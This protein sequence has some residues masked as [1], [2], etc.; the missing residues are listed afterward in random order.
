[1]EASA[2]G[3]QRALRSLGRR[4]LRERVPDAVR[5]EVLRYVE[6][7]RH[8]GRPWSEITA[9]L[10][11]SKSALTRWRRRAGSRGRTLR[12]VR[13]ESAL[14]SRGVSV[15]TAGGHRVEGLSLAEAVE[16]VSALG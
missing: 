11:L 10:R 4:G 6:E 16:V 15:V 8:A 14:A 1:M 13:V 9:S 3:A 5:A 12:R 7:A 2:R